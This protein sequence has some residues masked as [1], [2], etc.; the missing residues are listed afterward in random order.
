MKLSQINF[1]ILLLEKEIW[2][3]N[4]SEIK[5]LLKKLG[6]N[7]IYEIPNVIMRLMEDEINEKIEK[8]LKK[9]DETISR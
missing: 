1:F 9:L 2:I 3:N 8:E 5:S 4:I 6:L 7:S